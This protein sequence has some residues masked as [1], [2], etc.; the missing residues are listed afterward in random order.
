VYASDNGFLFGEHRRVELRWPFEEVIRI[1]LLL[2]HP[3]TVTAP[4][5]RVEQMALNIDL[6]PTLLDL[7]GIAVPADM[8]GLS[9]APALRQPDAPGRR[10]WLVEND[11]EFPYRVPSYSGV[12]TER[13]LYVEYDGASATLHDVVA[14]PAQARD[15]IDSAEGARVLP[16]LRAT[17]AALRRGERFDGA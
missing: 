13:Y 8:Q 11:R 2:R 6:A 4:G 14:D 3:P 1:P 16:E 10:A 12:H 7:A 15:L 17:L 5:R 9:L